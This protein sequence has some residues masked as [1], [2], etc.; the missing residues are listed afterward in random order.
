MPLQVCPVGWA[1]PFSPKALPRIFIKL[2]PSFL[3][4]ILSQFHLL[5]SVLNILH[6]LPVDAQQIGKKGN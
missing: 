2:G 1:Y 4:L 3:I 5:E 6:E